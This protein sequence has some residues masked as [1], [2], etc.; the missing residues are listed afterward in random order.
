MDIN[1]LSRHINFNSFFNNCFIFSEASN[2]FS[3]Y[4]SIINEIFKNA[5]ILSTWL[6]KETTNVVK[7]IKSSNNYPIDSYEFNNIDNLNSIKDL[8]L[9]NLNSPNYISTNSDI[10]LGHE[11]SYCQIFIGCTF[12]NNN[13]QYIFFDHYYAF[14]IFI[15]NELILD[16]INTNLIKTP[17]SIIKDDFLNVE[18]GIKNINFSEICVYCMKN[19]KLLSKH[20][21]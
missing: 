18:N 14:F 10:Y 13:L 9:F 12:L 21:L 3:K 5:G 4:N 7:F 20:N 15:E 16:Y 2:G 1:N 17:Y 8:N 19:N 6:Y 11:S